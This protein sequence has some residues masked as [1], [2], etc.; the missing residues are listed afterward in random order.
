M[1]HGSPLFPETPK[2]HRIHGGLRTERQEHIFTWMAVVAVLLYAT[3]W[4]GAITEIERVRNTPV[5]VA[6]GEHTEPAETPPSPAKSLSTFG[7]QLPKATYLTDA[8]LGFLHPL[9]GES[10]DLRYAPALPGARVVRTAPGDAVAVIDGVQVDFTAPRKPGIYPFSVEIDDARRSVEDISIVTLVPR[11]EK[12]AG[13]IGTYQ[14][15]TWPFERGGTPK[16]PRYAAPSGFIQVTPENQDFQISEHFRLRQFLTKDQFNVWPKYVLID[17]LLI[18][19]LELTIEQ[20]QAEGVRVENVHVMSGF[21]TPRYNVGGG[22]TAGRANLS[23]HMYGDGAD[24]YVDNNRDGQPDDITGD[25]RVTTADAEKFAR[26]AE[27]V[28]GEYR[29]LLGGV[30]VYPACCGHGPFTHVDVRGYRA[31]WRGSGSG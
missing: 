20:L 19:K 17:P 14:L 18:D 25:R 22:N 23:R 27:R 21:R 29:A 8:M 26:A 5:V 12:R 6:D 4:V 31:R 1:E 9:R 10:G 7:P 16:T 24:V 15:G 13:R 30:G 3:L 11:S 28:E 2:R